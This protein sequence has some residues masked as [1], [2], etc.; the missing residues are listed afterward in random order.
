MD[1]KKYFKEVQRY[2][3]NI[4]SM[5]KFE[6]NN[7]I[8]TLENDNI[9]A[10]VNQCFNNDESIENCTDKIIELYDNS[11]PQSRDDINKEPDRLAG[12]RGENTMESKILKYND[13]I[14]G[15]Y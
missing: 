11:T 4:S 15:K 9:Q 10:L 3:K 2:I 8:K 6:I 12:D 14:N 13:F 5:K 7:I 1:I